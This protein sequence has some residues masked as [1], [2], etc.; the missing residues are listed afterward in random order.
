MAYRRFISRAG[1]SAQMIVV[2]DAVDGPAAVGLFRRRILVPL[3]FATRFDAAERALVLRHER[4]HLE[5]GDL[6]ANAAALFMLALHWFNPLAHWAY[7][8][9]REDQEYSCDAAVVARAGAETRA[10][11]AAAMM[12]SAGG[13][14]WASRTAPATTCPM[15]RPQTLKRRLK[16]VAKH[17]SSKLASAGG[18]FALGVTALA[19]LTLTA[20]SGIAQEPVVKHVIVKRWKVPGAASD[21]AIAEIKARCGPEMTESLTKE[22]SRLEGKPVKVKTVVCGDTSTLGSDRLPKLEKARAHIATSPDVED[23][24]R[25]QILAAL[26][27]QIAALKAA[28]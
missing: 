23:A 6:W 2:T 28:R 10:A 16:M 24:E 9:F 19:G 4:V 25:G 26:D 7:R 11:Y 27:R 3:D 8:A 17:K 22:L 18:L 15:T 20:T 5:R 21:A 12:K 1:T 14:P 13:A